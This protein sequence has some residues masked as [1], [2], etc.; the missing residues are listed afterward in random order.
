MSL[1]WGTGNKL[2]CCIAAAIVCSG[3]TSTLAEDNPGSVSLQFGDATFNWLVGEHGSTE[4]TDTGYEF[5]GSDLGS[6]WAMSW[7]MM[8]S[9]SALA[10]SLVANFV[11]TNTGEVPV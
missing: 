10:E 11:V 3:S 4:Y 7:N 5:N 9:G 2:C 8:A 1:L 6:G